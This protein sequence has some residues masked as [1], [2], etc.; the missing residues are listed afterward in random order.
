MQQDKWIF[1]FGS[2]RG[3]SHVA[4]NLPCQ[5]S[6]K[7]EQCENFAIS[8]VCDGAGSCENSHIGSE[9]VTAR[10]ISQFKE[11]VKANKWV[12]DNILPNQETWHCIAKQTLK[13][14]RT[15]LER[16]SSDREL[17]FKSLSCTIIVVIAF[18]TG[19]LITHIGDGRAGYCNTKDEWQSIM[20]PLHGNE[21]NETVFITSDIWDDPIIDTY[22]ESNVVIDRVKAFCLLTDGCEKSSYECNLF[23]KEKELYYDPNIPYPLFFDPNVKVLPKLHR[24][25]KSQ[26][27]INTLWITFLTAGNEKLKIEPDDKTMVLGVRLIEDIYHTEVENAQETTA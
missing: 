24:Q 10:C 15:D 1:A 8:V 3:N 9:W 7:V 17:P 14:V 21:A 16:F 26:E 4:E 23:D 12:D 18:D 2:A 25:G 6:C 20:K 11:A 13:S 19:L 27:E 22:I 5:D